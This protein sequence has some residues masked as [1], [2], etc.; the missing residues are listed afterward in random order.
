MA[1]IL[2]DNCLYSYQTIFVDKNHFI[3]RDASSTITNSGEHV[4]ISNDIKTVK[5]E[6]NEYRLY[7][8]NLTVVS[9]IKDAE[10]IEF[11]SEKNILSIYFMKNQSMLSVVI[12]KQLM[13][14]Y[15]EQKSYLFPNKGNIFKNI[16]QSLLL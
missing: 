16:K 14:G 4:F 13:S 1:Q 3:K 8:P 5:L 12:V 10:I 7:N 2:D 15:I 11:S 6:N 9:E